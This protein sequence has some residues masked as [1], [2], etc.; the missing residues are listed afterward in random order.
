MVEISIGSETFS[1][2]SKKMEYPL[3]RE[4]LRRAR[5]E[6]PVYDPV[7]I[8]RCLSFMKAK[9]TQ[10]NIK[11]ETCIIALIAFYYADREDEKP[12]LDPNGNIIFSCDMPKRLLQILHLALNLVR[13][14]G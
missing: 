8:S 9:N 2:G 13:R 10:E 5:D 7:Y 14:G 6:K 11:V 1:L 4:L 12:E 3:Y